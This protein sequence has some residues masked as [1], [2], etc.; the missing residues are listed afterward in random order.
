VFDADL[1]KTDSEI[2]AYPK[3][4]IE[5]P[6]RKR[7]IRILAFTAIAA[8]SVI[9]PANAAFYNGSYILADCESHAIGDIK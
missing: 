3:D 2:R 9:G 5:T 8:I 1:V 7:N 4:R 6:R